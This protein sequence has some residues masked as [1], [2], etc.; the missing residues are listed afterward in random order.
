MIPTLRTERLTLAPATAGDLDAILALWTDPDVRRYRWDDRVV[1]REKAAAVLDDVIAISEDG[2]GLWIVRVEGEDAVA[3]CVGLRPTPAPGVEPLVAFHPRYRGHGYAT[4][5]LRALL[6]H[7]F[8]TLGFRWLSAI[9]DEPNEAS[10][11]LV[12]RLGFRRTEMV[13]G[14]KN[15]LL[16]YVLYASDWHRPDPRP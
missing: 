10:A 15:L 16:G 6:D 1:S 5:A 12:E 8:G 13:M 7:A 14:R 4:E 9:V 3:G 2:L 11:R